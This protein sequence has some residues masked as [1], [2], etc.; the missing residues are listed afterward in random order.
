MVGGQQRTALARSRDIRD[1]E[2]DTIWV[3]FPVGSWAARPA[4][5]TLV[6]CRHLDH[7]PWTIPANRAISFS[8]RIALRSLRGHRSARGNW[9][10]D[11]AKYVLAD[12]L[13]ADVFAKAKVGGV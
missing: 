13:A 9:A 7:H 11:R 12:K 10:E 6:L 1:Y 5:C 8:S 3:K 2:N 4:D